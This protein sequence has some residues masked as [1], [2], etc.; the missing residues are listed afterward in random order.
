M[1]EADIFLGVSC[2]ER[3][4][5]GDGYVS[6]TIFRKGKDPIALECAY[7]GFWSAGPGCKMAQPKMRAVTP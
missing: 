3:D 5:D 1:G 2:V 7:G 6:C 4:S